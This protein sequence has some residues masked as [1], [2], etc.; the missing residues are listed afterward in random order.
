M[1]KWLV[2]GLRVGAREL[3]FFLSKSDIRHIF[4]LGS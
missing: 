2:A 3:E 4:N 1:A